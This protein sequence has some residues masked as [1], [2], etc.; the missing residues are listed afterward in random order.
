M[1]YWVDNQT[2][3]AVRPKKDLVHSEVVRW[4]NDQLGVAP[5]IPR[6]EWFNMIQSE[7]L[8][9]ATA[10]GI[11]PD[12]FDDGQIGQALLEFID[13]QPL[14]NGYSATRKYQS[15]DIVKID[16]VYYEAYN[17]DGCLGKDPRDP[18]NRPSGW[19]NQDINAPYHWVEIGRSLMLPEIG[20]PIYLMNNVPRE[21]LIKLRNDGQLSATKFWRIAELNPNIVSNGLLSVADLRANVIRALDDGKGVDAGR[22]INSFQDDAMIKITGYITGIQHK[23]DGYYGGALKISPSDIPASALSDQTGGDAVFTHEFNTAFQHPTKTSNEIR[24]KNIA[25]LACIRI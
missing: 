2:A 13:H 18:A 4:F 9:I 19:T 20:S 17:P 23:R 10:L 24:M 12:K 22:V 14:S 7:L 21:G 25:M 1:V 16:G 8:S 6:A 11:T 5:T 15:G 3:V